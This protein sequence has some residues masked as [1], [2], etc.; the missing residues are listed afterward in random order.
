VLGEWG[1]V[2][3][4]PLESHMGRT[5]ASGICL[6]LCFLGALYSRCYPILARPDLGA[7][8]SRGSLRGMGLARP[9]DFQL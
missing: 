4:G 2:G 7:A 8:Q 3:S 6:A 1:I 9:V 5:E